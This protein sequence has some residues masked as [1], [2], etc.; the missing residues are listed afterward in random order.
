VYLNTCYSESHC[1][2]MF[3][4]TLF[5]GQRVSCIQLCYV[6]WLIFIV[7]LSPLQAIRMDVVEGRNYLHKLIVAQNTVNDPMVDFPPSATL[8]I[9]SLLYVSSLVYYSMSNRHLLE[10]HML[11]V[12]V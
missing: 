12:P 11:V 5:G 2:L 4:G 6:H 10:P 7:C 8:E 9:R 3:N 1:S